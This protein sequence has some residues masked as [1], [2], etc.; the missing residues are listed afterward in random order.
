M[1]ST[2]IKK[3][4]PIKLIEYSDALNGRIKIEKA[5]KGKREALAMELT[6]KM[7]IGM[8]ECGAVLDGFSGGVVKEL[9]LAW[10][11]AGMIETKHGATVVKRIRERKTT[12]RPAIKKKKA[13][14]D[15]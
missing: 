7:L 2:K 11:S 1:E 6:E 9:I 8:V 5:P 3:K 4:K 13:A 12:K 15:A 10:D 14:S